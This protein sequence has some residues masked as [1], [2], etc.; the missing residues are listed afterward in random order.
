MS[1]GWNL[2][3]Y[4]ALSRLPGFAH[5]LDQRTT[6][7]AAERAAEL[8]GCRWCIERCRHDCRKAGLRGECVL[9]ER[10]RSALAFVEAAGRAEQSA[11]QPDELI[12]QQAR[13]CLSDAEL[14]ELT[15]IV[16]EHHCLES[17]DSNRSGS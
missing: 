8:S 16:A 2:S 4:L 13:C 12:L 11:G 7:L 14:A 10:E 17:L 9:T 5:T 3:G 15:A 6:L 1:P